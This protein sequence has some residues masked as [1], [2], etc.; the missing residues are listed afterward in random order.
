MPEPCRSCAR[1]TLDFGGCR[2]QAFLIAGDA[3][4]TD[5]V[6]TLSPHRHLVDAAVAAGEAAAPAQRVSDEWTYRAAPAS[7]RLAAKG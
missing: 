3:A 6:C 5:P 1:K 2:C 4:L 7:R